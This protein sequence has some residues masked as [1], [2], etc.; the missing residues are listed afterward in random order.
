[1]YQS[2]SNVPLNRQ[3][4]V[5]LTLTNGYK[6]AKKTSDHLLSPSRRLITTAPTL[7]L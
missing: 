5:K 1:M 2:D 6:I 3:N 4:Q 7:S